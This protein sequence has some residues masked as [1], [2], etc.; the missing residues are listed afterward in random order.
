M[1]ALSFDVNLMRLLVAAGANPLLATQDN[2]TPLMAALGLG[3]ERASLIS[4]KEEQ[5]PK[6]LE[7]VKLTVELGVDVNA[8]ETATGLTA[9]H[10]AAFYGG[11]ERIIQYL[12]EK[13][14]NLNA[15]TKA[16]QTALA[17]ASN[18]APKGKVERNLVPLAYWKGTV[19]LLLKLGATPVSASVAKTSDV[20][21]ASTIK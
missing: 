6:V 20:G 16:G 15:K 17:I 2:V 5:E 21:S 13:G 19:D 18:I 7:M 9:L 3:R 8:A 12:A 11:S 14:A 10:C 1:A 4:Y